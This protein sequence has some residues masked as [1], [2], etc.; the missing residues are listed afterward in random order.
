MVD[1]IT[2][3]QLR[4]W[5]SD[6]LHSLAGGLRRMGMERDLSRGQEYLWSMVVRELEYRH[7]R[8]ATWGPRCWCDLCVPPFPRGDDDLV[9]AER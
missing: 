5:H 6:T 7:R 1:R 9:V 4:A 8:P 2:R 3:F